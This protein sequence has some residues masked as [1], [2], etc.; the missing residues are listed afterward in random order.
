MGLSKSIA[1]R[2]I[3]SVQSL[4]T[5][6]HRCGQQQFAEPPHMPLWLLSCDLS[7]TG[8]PLDDGFR[9]LCDSLS[10][11]DNEPAGPTLGTRKGAGATNDFGMT[12][13]GRKRVNNS[14]QVIHRPAP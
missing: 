2:V 14:S 10:R 4:R 13:S 8:L 5:H 7:E 1:I 11:G 9:D 3:S 12:G 6:F